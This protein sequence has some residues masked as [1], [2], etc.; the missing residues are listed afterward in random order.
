MVYKKVNRT[1]MMGLIF[2]FSSYPV[3]IK[4]PSF[5]CSDKLAHVAAYGVLASSIYVALKKGNVNKHHVVA[6][7]FAI[8]FLYGVSD[9]IHQYFVPGRQGDI[10]DVIANGIGAL[11]FPLAFQHRNNRSRARDPGKI[12]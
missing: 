1:A 10:F 3:A 2:Y 8:S 9:E 6:V 5:S 12:R 4:V 7:A 11:C